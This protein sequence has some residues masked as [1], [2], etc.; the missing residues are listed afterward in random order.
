[1]EKFEV[2]FALKTPDEAGTD[3]AA[4]PTKWLIPELLPEA[5]PAPFTEFR[6]P[7]VTR[8]R[9]SYPEALPPGLL[10]RFIVRTHEMSESF[11]EWRWR[12]GVVLGWL[13]A[14]ALVRL[15][16]Q[17]R[18][19]EVAVINGP[20]PERQ[21]LFD[22]IRA[23][24]TELHGHVPVVEEVQIPEAPDKW[25]PMI[26]LRMAERERDATLKVTLGDEPE[27]KRIQ[28]SVAQ[29]LDS[30]E[31][32]Q[33]RRACGPDPEERAPLFVSYAHANEK[34]LIPLRQH[35]THLSQQGYIQPWN[36]R[37][38][39]AGEQ[40]EAGIMKELNRAA[41]V[42]LFYTTAARISEFMQEKEV[43]MSLDRVDRGE[44]RLIWVPLERNDLRPDH[45]IEK[46]IGRLECATRDRKLIYDFEPNQIG[47][48]Q[49]EHSIR[50]AVDRWR[51]RGVG[52]T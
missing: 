46:R 9:F 36:D 13:G 52:Q 26:D 3:S 10:P 22:I 24:L 7:G 20:L 35:L 38:L 1:M 23:H 40:W 11:A 18:R 43:P 39:V 25:V 6:A 17:Q 41:I 15:D 27:T 33:A 50:R 51:R 21:S 48:M 31:S 14:R 19:T 49:V 32:V 28:L 34:E 5:Q 12:S 37:D 4:E 29:T 45:A 30:V 2:A 8:L 47:W 44:C 16:R 42:L